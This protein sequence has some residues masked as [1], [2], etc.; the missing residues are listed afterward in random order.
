MNTEKVDIGIVGSG[1]IAHGLG[2]SLQ[3]HP[4]YNLSKILTRRKISDIKPLSIDKEKY[5]NS[6]DELINNSKLI[7]EC[8]GDPIYATDVIKKILDEQIPVVTMDS[9]LQ[10]TSGSW[11]SRKGLISEAE[12]DQP[13]S[14]AVLYED[15][16]SMG[17]NPLV[18]GN[19][20]GFLN[21]NPTK[22]D[23]NFWSKKNGISLVQVTSFTDGTK[24]QIEQV[25]V[26]NGL[27]AE[28]TTR[29]MVGTVC[30]NY[31][32]GAKQLAETADKSNIV[33]SDYVLS[34]KSPAGVFIAAKH[35]ELQSSYLKYY[36]MG[37]GPY[38]V[39]T[40]PFHLCHLEVLKT[41]NRIL[42]SK[43]VL[44]DN[45]LNPRFSVATVSKRL[46]KKGEVLKRGIGSF[47]VRGEAI[48]ISE[49]P[50]HVPIGLIFDV[51]TKR[52][53]EPGEIISFDDIEIPEST[54]LIAWKETILN[55]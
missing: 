3:E 29:G 47:D 38:Y 13:G 1:F 39:L 21:H 14:I 15:A 24:I 4:R 18:L 53:I 16:L 51:I 11:L 48:K 5:T 55:K 40:R 25:L 10:I 33:I 9:E 26:A 45:S 44:L 52:D 34:Q 17:F 32:D 31:Q 50:S 28:I 23:M 54:A 46:I 20:K 22:E 27:G 12:G 49:L 37:D 35:Q 42:N 7:I 41:V 43:N 19:I 8:T 6:L 30:D 2:L 36:K